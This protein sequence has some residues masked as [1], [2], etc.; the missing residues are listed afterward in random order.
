MSLE[1]IAENLSEED[2][3]ELKAFVDRTRLVHDVANDV[4]ES[5][6][7]Q[8]L[9]DKISKHIGEDCPYASFTLSFLD[10]PS[11]PS[12]LAAK[13]HFNS[14]ATTEED[15]HNTDY[16][17]DLTDESN[18]RTTGYRVITEGHTIYNPQT[19][20]KLK[21]QGISHYVTAPI[22]ANGKIVGTLSLGKTHNNVSEELEVETVDEIAAYVSIAIQNIKLQAENYNQAVRDTITTS[23]HYIKNLLTPMVAYCEMIPG[24]LESLEGP[25]EDK[26]S[27]LKGIATIGAYSHQIASTL[28]FMASFEGQTEKKPYLGNSDNDNVIQVPK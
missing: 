25:E 16:E 10:N 23:H 1:K 22:K 28:D 3:R 21:N 27:I 26:K 12:K 9:V 2:R 8:S 17:I 6:S 4:L 18:H 5:T 14:A 15:A 13:Y 19:E 7:E 11:K 24:Y 20:G